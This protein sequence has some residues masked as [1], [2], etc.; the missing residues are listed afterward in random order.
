MTTNDAPSARD[1]LIDT[2]YELF[3]RRGICDVGVDEVVAK[4]G[5]AKATLYRH[6]SSKED[7]GAGVHGPARRGVDQ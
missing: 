7:L 3:T 1:R 5:V 4:A 2:S 6:F